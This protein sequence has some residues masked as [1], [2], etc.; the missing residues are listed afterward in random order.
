M[1]KLDAELVDLSKGNTSFIVTAEYLLELAAK[2]KELFE[3]SQPA[4]KNKILRAVL[5]N[6]NLNQKKLQ[7]NLLQPFHGLVFNQKS[8]T[9]LTTIEEVITAI[10]RDFGTIRS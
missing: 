1:D 8:S 7:L 3:S 6:L 5:A 10:K 4:Q 2:S 9:W